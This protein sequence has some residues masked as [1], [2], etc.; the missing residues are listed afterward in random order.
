MTVYGSKDHF[1]G[2][3]M[4]IKL[5]IEKHVRERNKARNLPTSFDQFWEWR[6]QKRK[7]YLVLRVSS[8]GVPYC[9]DTELAFFLLGLYKLLEGSCP[10]P[11]ECGSRALLCQLAR[12]RTC[13]A[14]FWGASIRIQ[15]DWALEIA[16]AS[17]RPQ[18]HYSGTTQWQDGTCAMGRCLV[19]RCSRHDRVWSNP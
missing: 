5:L 13:S 15:W 10:I 7:L 17:L 12:S 1:F 6:E 4:H 16:V 11:L 8:L 14:V 19:G 3:K 18:S 9:G 2:Y